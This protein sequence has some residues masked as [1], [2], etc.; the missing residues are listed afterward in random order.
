MR[1]CHA[2]IVACGTL[3]AVAAEQVWLNWGRVAGDVI[4]TWTSNAFNES[5]QWSYTSGGPYS[6]VWA[7]EVT[8]CA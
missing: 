2:A 5:V 8:T 1:A 7:D 4:V 6:T 3:G